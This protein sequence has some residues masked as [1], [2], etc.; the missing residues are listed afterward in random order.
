[1]TWPER[2][3]IKPCHPCTEPDDYYVCHPEFLTGGATSYVRLDIH[4]AM[5]ERAFRDGLSYGTICE[6]TDPNEAWRSSA[7]RAALA[8][9]GE[10]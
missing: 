4:E 9:T 10:G 8:R 7:A 5:V 3:W 1:M 2:I 6:V